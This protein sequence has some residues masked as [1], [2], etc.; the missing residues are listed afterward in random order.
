MNLATACSLKPDNVLYTV[1]VKR[2]NEKSELYVF[3]GGDEKLSTIQT[4]GFEKKYDIPTSDIHFV[5]DTFIYRDDSIEVVQTKI[6][7][8]LG[9][10]RKDD[11]YLYGERRVTADMQKYIINE[12]LKNAYA[13][14]VTD[15]IDVEVLNRYFKMRMVKKHKK[16][17]DLIDVS[18][19]V[20]RDI[21][22]ISHQQKIFIRSAH[23]VL[24]TI[25]KR[26]IVYEYVPLAF[27]MTRN[28]N[29]VMFSSNPF[30]ATMNDDFVYN[31]PTVFKETN[32]SMHLGEYHLDGEELFVV[33]REDLE[34]SL[35]QRKVTEKNEILDLYFDAL[36]L[37]EK[38]AHGMKTLWTK[39]DGLKQDVNKF[40]F[41]KYIDVD[42]TECHVKTCKFT[43]KPS[44]RVT[45]ILNKEPLTI[46][47]KK[48]FH[49]FN[50]D[51]MVPYMVYQSSKTDYQCKTLNK[52]IVEFVTPE[53]FEHWVE[54]DLRKYN[55]SN[56]FSKSKFAPRLGMK[57]VIPPLPASEAES[58]EGTAK[59]YADVTIM[60]HGLYYFQVKTYVGES[61][62]RLDEINAIVD[63]FNESC[64]SKINNILDGYDNPLDE[65][66]A[67]TKINNTLAM[68]TYTQLNLK[69]NVLSNDA[70]LKKLK[71][72]AFFTLLK[73]NTD[74]EQ[75]VLGY[76]RVSNFN[77]S[78]SVTRFISKNYQ[79]PLNELIDRLA[80]E[81]GTSKEEAMKKYENLGG[82]INMEIIDNNNNTYFSPVNRYDII[83]RCKLSM[84]Q[85]GVDI[86]NATRDD[87]HS[88]ILKL[89]AILC[90]DN[91]LVLEVTK[92]EQTSLVEREQE[93]Q[94]N[95]S[96]TDLTLAMMNNILENTTYD[97]EEDDDDDDSIKRADSVSGSDSEEDEE[98]DSVKRADSFSGSDNE[99]DEEEVEGNG[100][101]P[102]RAN[103]GKEEKGKSSSPTTTKSE[104]T[105]NRKKSGPQ[106]ARVDFEDVEMRNAYP[107]DSAPPPVEET[108]DQTSSEEN[109]Q[110]ELNEFKNVKK[111]AKLMKKYHRK[112]IIEKLQKEDPVL[113]DYEGKTISYKGDVTDKVKKNYMRSCPAVD[114]RQPVVITENEKSYI[115]AHHADSYRG[116]IKTGSTEQLKKR[117][118]YICPLVW[119]PISRVSLTVDELNKNDGKC[120]KPYEEIP[121]IM[122]SESD[123]KAHLK[124]LQT[125]ED[126]K[127]KKEGRKAEKVEYVFDNTIP[128]KSPML[129]KP[130]LHPAKLQSVCCGRDKEDKKSRNK[131][132]SVIT[133][134]PK[135]S[136]IIKRYVMKVSNIPIDEGRYGTLPLLL[137]EYMNKGRTLDSCA[138]LRTPDKL[139][140]FVRMGLGLKVRQKLLN[141]FVKTLQ[142]DAAQSVDDLVSLIKERMTLLEYIG[143]N[144][145]N[146]LKSYIPKDVCI[147][148]EDDL[149]K[150]KKYMA[151]AA[152]KQ[153]AKVMNLEHVLPLV[154]DAKTSTFKK[155]ERTYDEKVI[156]R[157]FVF[158]HS[159]ENFKAYLEDDTIL[160]RIDDLYDMTRYEWF[161]P[162]NYNFIF[163]DMTNDEDI[164][165]LCKK[166]RSGSYQ[167]DSEKHVFMLKINEDFEVMIRFSKED[168]KDQRGITV[169]HTHA[170]AETGVYEMV[171]VHRKLCKISRE[172]DELDGDEIFAILR[173]MTSDE[174]DEGGSSKVDEIVIVLNYYLKVSGFLCNGVYIPLQVESDITD[175]MLTTKKNVSFT[176][177]DRMKHVVGDVFK[178]VSSLETRGEAILKTIA[179]VRPETK[180]YKL[181]KVDNKFMFGVEGDHHYLTQDAL[182]A[183]LEDDELDIDLFVRY[184]ID[185]ERRKKLDEHKNKLKELHKH[186]KKLLRILSDD[187]YYEHRLAIDMIRH[188]MNP[189]P[190][191]EKYNHLKKVL[192]D[193]IPDSKENNEAI[194]R[195]VYTKGLH[196]LS[197]ESYKY[198]VVD[199]DSEIIFDG[200]DLLNGMLQ[201]HYESMS[202]PYR[203][204]ETTID[205]VVGNY[206]WNKSTDD[207]L[208]V[209]GT[210]KRDPLTH[211]TDYVFEFESVNL[212]H[213]KSKPKSKVPSD[214]KRMYLKDDDGEVMN[215][216]DMVMTILRTVAEET[217]NDTL[218]TTSV[219]DLKTKVVDA[220]KRNW[221]SRHAGHWIKMSNDHY[222]ER[223]ID[224]LSL[225]N[226]AKDIYQ[227]ESYNM[228]VIEYS[229][230]LNS[231]GVGLILV[232]EKGKGKKPYDLRDGAE[233]LLPDTSNLDSVK[234][235][236]LE[237]DDDK[238]NVVKN[239]LKPVVKK[240]EYENRPIKM[241]YN[242]D[243][244]V[245]TLKEHLTEVNKDKTEEVRY[246]HN[247]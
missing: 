188:K 86:E 240:I 150:F 57:L 42:K 223:R 2:T 47:I 122:F 180:Y 22:K 52:Q 114:R 138:G 116:Y 99:D 100:K 206:V 75:L 135:Q 107:Y 153:Y 25:L 215:N 173:K 19:K 70:I 46:N 210:Y 140:C 238:N 132:K 64:L 202:N 33:T 217:K 62:I 117:N 196:V 10:E 66:M 243:E 185:D 156:E 172:P 183:T 121:L 37:V 129:M 193:L 241:L 20:Y 216:N 112:Y 143:L 45:T 160:K 88:N 51:E 6:A 3:R 24:S 36:R 187:K 69:N 92:K 72:H 167:D 179:D 109:V 11:V 231:M 67:T 26:D 169:K 41:A 207:V 130:N 18:T 133:S 31:D 148:N 127:A 68:R 146:T 176:F 195:D 229:T 85:I 157:E 23:E 14:D 79:L 197:K 49:L 213:L 234:Y 147:E 124:R 131:S 164:R 230:Y 201:R 158:F 89:V 145:G 119:C 232:G 110:S 142:N 71:N 13:Q 191:K 7:A 115:D 56:V 17:Q 204:I 63:H 162:K 101:S 4:S 61:E 77:T 108:N 134:N 55:K 73:N 60:E 247:L 50:V 224:A 35:S 151:S 96:S 43:V 32:G 144:G 106:E 34:K 192:D 226:I 242:W 8:A 102:N 104:E 120:P 82:T 125:E 190:L 200:V 203:Q 128:Y 178:S 245:K 38:S 166:Y 235:L 182:S 105:R 155:R 186:V 221:N 177:R 78:D 1:H 233:I 9:I 175:K 184:Q 48:I 168:D 126:D 137:N 80:T 40:D 59:R 30:D 76:K 246:L 21:E 149:S 174:E 239:H 220:H 205:D 16:S 209:D 94:Q 58:S 163:F 227:D 189:F 29:G 93:A 159:F 222:D 244:L 39:M 118:H 12:F 95:T 208:V 141:A 90:C 74:D 212:K 225:D 170:T 228:G 211:R 5:D 181:R 83:V 28:N 98:G 87:Y 194:K 84:Y 44:E 123:K 214:F 103:S 139:D 54:E 97:N 65:L 199:E 165:I 27:R 81:Y 15:G 198:P 236:I 152:G 219:D 113:F 136:E 53:Q 218:R 111:D 91:P 237:Y 171:N 161:N 154:K